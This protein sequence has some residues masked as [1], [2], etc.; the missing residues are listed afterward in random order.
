[1]NNKRQTQHHDL[2]PR[3]EHTYEYAL[4]WRT[5]LFD[6]I[7]VTTRSMSLSSKRYIGFIAST[8]R[9]KSGQIGPQRSNNHWHRRV[10]MQC[11][12]HMFFT[13][14]MQ[15]IVDCLRRGALSM[16]SSVRAG[17]RGKFGCRC[18]NKSAQER[19]KEGKKERRKDN[20]YGY[21]YGI[22]AP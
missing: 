11:P 4:S 22:Y 7:S 5:A 6:G 13:L 20:E 3:S 2:T 12:L 10:S 16:C 14:W 1:M 8:A 18:A 21:E 15:K 17:V 9:V 19:R